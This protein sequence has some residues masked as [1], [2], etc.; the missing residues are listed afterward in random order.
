M[1]IRQTQST[2]VD[3]IKRKQYDAGFASRLLH[4][5]VV[6]RPDG[7]LEIGV[8]DPDDDINLAEPWSI[9]RI[10]I[11]AWASAPKSFAAMPGAW[12]MPRPTVAINAMWGYASSMSGWHSL[13]DFFEHL[14]QLAV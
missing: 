3:G 4:E 5:G 7:F 8:F 13:L 2:A 6:D 9:M 1:R 11:C 10:L 14:V 12:A